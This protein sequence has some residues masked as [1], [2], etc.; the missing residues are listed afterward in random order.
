M[1]ECYQA[2]GAEKQESGKTQTPSVSSDDESKYG[3]DLFVH[4][5]AGNKNTHLYWLSLVVINVCEFSVTRKVIFAFSTFLVLLPEIVLALAI[6]K[7]IKFRS[8]QQ[9]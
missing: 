1:K 8:P 5:E 9:R 6:N 3:R 7:Q 4:S 2:G